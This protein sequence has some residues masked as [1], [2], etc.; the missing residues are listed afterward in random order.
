MKR[1]RV[2][3]PRICFPRGSISFPL[4]GYPYGNHITQDMLPK[5]KHILGD[6]L[7]GHMGKERELSY[8]I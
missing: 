4:G 3:I 1:H 7:N 2:Y 8:G 5:G 6:N